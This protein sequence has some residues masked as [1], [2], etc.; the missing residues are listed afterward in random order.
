MLPLIKKGATGYIVEHLQ[1]TLYQAN[2]SGKEKLTPDG[3][4]GWKTLNQVTLFQKAKRLTVDGEVG[5]NT[6][7]ELYKDVF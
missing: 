7:R 3:D 6:W 2:Y 5:T 4:F 1:R